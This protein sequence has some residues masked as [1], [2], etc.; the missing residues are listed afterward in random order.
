[1]LKNVPT[2]ALTLYIVFLISCI[3]WLIV[4]S[5]FSAVWSGV[6]R[7]VLLL[8]LITGVSLVMEIKCL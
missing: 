1:M 5:S 3:S 8:I 7:V 6:W 4:F 2:V